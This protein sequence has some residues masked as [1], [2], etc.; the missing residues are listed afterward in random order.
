MPVNKCEPRL[1]TIVNYVMV[2]I[3]NLKR[4]WLYP[5]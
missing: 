4:L 5:I 1:L 2:T 3:V